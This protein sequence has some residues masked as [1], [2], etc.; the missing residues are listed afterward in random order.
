MFNQ[1]S[2]IYNLKS[3]ISNPSPYSF[4]IASMVE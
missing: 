1:I 4:I 2:A 3:S